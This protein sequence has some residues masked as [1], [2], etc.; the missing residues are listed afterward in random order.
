MPSGRASKRKRREQARCQQPPVTV[1]ILDVVDTEK[2][3]F[4]GQ[5]L[6]SV[7]DAA[8]LAGLVEL[9]E[10]DCVHAL[11]DLAKEFYEKAAVFREPLYIFDMVGQFVGFPVAV[12]RMSDGGEVEVCDAYVCVDGVDALVNIVTAGDPWTAREILE[13]LYREAP[14][15]LLKLAAASKQIAA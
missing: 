10:E 14:L 13:S 15:L 4:D 8:R 3:V 12:S 7:E 9:S 1:Q 5:A 2:R 11:A 6:P